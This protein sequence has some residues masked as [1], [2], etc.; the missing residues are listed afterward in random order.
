MKK[1]RVNTGTVTYA[2]KGRDVLRRKGYNVKI[3]KSQQGLNKT[4]C[5]YSIIVFG[6]I[7][8]IEQ[9][10]RNSGVKI[11]DIQEIKNNN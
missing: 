3:E 9:L 5:G 6:E 4:G 1:Y 10:L 11:L 7:S 2:I 8:V